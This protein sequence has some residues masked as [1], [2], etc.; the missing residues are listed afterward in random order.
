MT[1]RTDTKIVRL[2]DDAALADPDVGARRSVLQENPAW[3]ELPPAQRQPVIE[4]IAAAPTTAERFAR[5]QA[6]Q[7]RNLT[8]RMEWLAER[9]RE[10]RR[11]DRELLKPPPPE[12]LRNYL[13]LPADAPSDL[14]G[15]AAASAEGL[16]AEFQPLEAMRR[17]AGIPV[18]LPS[19]VAKAAA[20]IVAEAA[21]FDVGVKRVGETPLNVAALAR[22]VRLHAGSTTADAFCAAL[23]RLAATFKRQG[24]LFLAVLRWTFRAAARDPAWTVTA[25]PLRGALLWCHANAVMEVLV[26]QNVVPSKASDILDHPGSDGLAA[27]FTRERKYDGVLLDPAALTTAQLA[28]AIA[29][30]A[31]G[32]STVPVSDAD[33]DAARTM[34]GFQIGEHW[35][36][37]TDLLLPPNTRDVGTWLT[38][39]GGGELGRLGVL[40]LPPPFDQRDAEALVCALVEKIEQGE[41][42][43]SAWAFLRLMDPVRISPGTRAELRRLLGD[44]GSRSIAAAGGSAPR[45]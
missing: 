13:R 42:K 19:S 6:A 35:V 41:E 22:A 26:A 18:E 31:L 24:R 43:D 28:A 32:G 7:E 8:W 3:F 29:L 2:A 30:Y 4:A 1:I 34:T 12:V 15:I 20:T 37:V 21:S 14:R 36:P 45:P 16:L 33:R 38:V 9:I 25:E 11:S 44:E 39:D 17:L 23:G 27:V 40:E 5:L 10:E